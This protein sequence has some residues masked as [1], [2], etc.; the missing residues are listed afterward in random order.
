MLSLE[1]A[2]AL[3]LTCRGS[4][5]TA[6][7][8]VAALRDEWDA[9]AD[10]DGKIPADVAATFVPAKIVHILQEYLTMATETLAR[11]ALN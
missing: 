8:C 11:M 1:E 5:W 7:T 10:A 2:V 3:H 4:Q 6:D 9:R